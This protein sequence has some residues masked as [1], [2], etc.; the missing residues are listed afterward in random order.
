MVERK[1]WYAVLTKPQKE[2]YAELNL[3]R[4]GVETF[5]PRLSLPKSATRKKVVSLFPN[6]L[7]ARFE[8]F[9]NA[10][11]S[12]MWCP[13]VNRVVSFGG[14]PAVIDEPIIGFLMKQGGSQGVIPGRCNVRIG[15]EIR[16]DGGPFDGLIGLIQEPPSA[17]GRIKILL[18]LV[19]RPIRVDVPLEF[20]NAG[21][22]ISGGTA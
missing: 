20:V 6:Y 3:R 10:W 8:V 9:S 22:V 7:F 15:Q 21:W 4:R 12:V 13:G 5:Y 14:S 1:Q 19:N 2:E 16:I 11:M 18:T 17:K